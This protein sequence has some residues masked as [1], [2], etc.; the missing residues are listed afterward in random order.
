M[1]PADEVK[2]RSILN[3]VGIVDN[4]RVGI[5]WWLEQEKQYGLPALQV[6]LFL[7]QAWR[8]VIKPSEEAVES[9]LQM[10]KARAGDDETY[11][12]YRLKQDPSIAE[13]LEK[14]M[15]KKD[16]A[17]AI[18]YLVRSAQIEAVG[19]ILQLADGGETYE[20]GLTASWSIFSLDD[21]LE[22]KKPFGNLTQLFFDCNPV[23]VPSKL[24]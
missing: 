12:S 7:R 24:G 15:E 1:S 11:Q 20:D 17:I 16:L 21:E 3:E 18:T 2:L 14:A 8:S 23:V 22:P 10:L 19:S 5:D 9:L 13:C 4:A 6:A